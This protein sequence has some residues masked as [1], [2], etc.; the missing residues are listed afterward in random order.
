MTGLGH[1]PSGSCFSEQAETNKTKPEE[2]CQSA[3]DSPCSSV[4][5]KHGHHKAKGT[6]T[7]YI[8]D[9]SPIRIRGYLESNKIRNA[10]R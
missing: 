3:C 10:T 7:P 8:G 5:E 2:T 4:W 1:T 6:K 9:E